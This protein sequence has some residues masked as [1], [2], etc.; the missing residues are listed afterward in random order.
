MAGINNIYV[1]TS[2][3]VLFRPLRILHYCIYKIAKLQFLKESLSISPDAT[4]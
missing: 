3:K 4:Q 1:M 2:I